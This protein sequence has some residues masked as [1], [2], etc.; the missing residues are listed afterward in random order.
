MYFRITPKYLGRK[1]TFSPRKVVDYL[2]S[3][4]EDGDSEV[5]EHAV[6]VA[7]SVQDC[8]NL[9]EQIS[10]KEGES[11]YIYKIIDPDEPVM[12]HIWPFGRDGDALAGETVEYRYYQPVDG[13]FVG[14]KKI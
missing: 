9:A 3:W 10:R 1:V 12:F 14:R 5:V 2:P 7:H 4:D 13:I 8:L 6:C 11:Y